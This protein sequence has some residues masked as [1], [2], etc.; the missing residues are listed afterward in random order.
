MLTEKTTL[1]MTALVLTTAMGFPVV[2]DQSGGEDRSTGWTYEDNHVQKRPCTEAS[3]S[4]AS[5]LPVMTESGNSLYH[6]ITHTNKTREGVEGV[7]KNVFTSRGW[8]PGGMPFSVLYLSRKAR[9]HRPPAPPQLP[10]EA[11]PQPLALTAVAAP[12]AGYDTFGARRHYSI[13]PQLFVSYGWGPI[14]K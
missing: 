7:K 9:V 1:T 14:G 13:I 10:G 11:V 2:V 12:H 4:C 5:Q 8:G 3:P 6:R